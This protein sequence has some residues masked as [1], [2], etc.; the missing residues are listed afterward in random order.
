MGTDFQYAGSA[1][2]PRF[3]R[4]VCAVAEI[5]GGVKNRTFKKAFGNRRCKTLWIL[6][7]IFEFR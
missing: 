1:S 7:W 3:D 6:V 2:Y 4:E 5:S